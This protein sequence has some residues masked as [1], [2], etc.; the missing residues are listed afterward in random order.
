MNR[1]ELVAI[2]AR[3]LGWTSRQARELLNA[4]T[5]AITQAV[6]DGGELVV[7]RFGKFKVRRSAARTIR[8]PKTKLMMKVQASRKVVFSPAKVL[9]DSVNM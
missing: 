6:M 4:V 2:V 1:T 8:N 7:P 3:D 5:A 9:R